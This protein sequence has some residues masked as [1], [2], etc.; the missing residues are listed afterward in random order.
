MS[1]L[2]ILSVTTVSGPPDRVLASL[3][4]TRAALAIEQHVLAPLA[5]SG[6]AGAALARHISTCAGCK[7]DTARLDGDGTRGSAI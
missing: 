4:G 5:R 2:R 1:A 7:A 6:R 3:P